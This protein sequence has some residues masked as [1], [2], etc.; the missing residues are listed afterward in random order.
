ML[1]QYIDL[2]GS[3]LAHIVSWQPHGRCFRVHDPKGFEK[4]VLPRFFEKMTRYA[5]FLRQLKLWGFRRLVQKTPD[6]G[7]FYNEMCLRSKVSL[8]RRISR[9]LLSTSGRHAPCYYIPGAGGVV[10]VLADAV[11]EPDFYSMADMPSSS[12]GVTAHDNGD[13]VSL[14]EVVSSNVAGGQVRNTTTFASVHPVQSSEPSSA[15]T[16]GGVLNTSSNVAGAAS[17]EYKS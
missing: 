6:Q 12:V 9:K 5:S 1:L 14:L 7:A 3:D 13:D 11:N 4:L 15:I 10:A 2:H 16:A 8:S 17:S